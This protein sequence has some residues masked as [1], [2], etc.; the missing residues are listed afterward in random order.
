MRPLGTRAGLAA[1]VL[2]SLVGCAGPVEEP[3]ALA[4]LEEV[5]LSGEQ[6]YLNCESCHALTTGASH[7]V[8]PNLGGIADQPAASREGYAYSPALQQSGLTWNEGTLAAFIMESGRLV[9]GTWMVY[10][11]HLTPEESRRLTQYVLRAGQGADAGAAWVDP[12]DG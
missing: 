9:P 10:H 4:E 1:G 7:R 8:G 2:A 6:L 12:S 11:N 5:T 3:P